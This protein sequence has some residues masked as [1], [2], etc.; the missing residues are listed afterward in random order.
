MAEET[1][2]ER[3]ERATGKRVSD[4]REKGNVLRSREL[5]TTIL[6][7]AS[8]G[9][10][11][12][13]GGGV[14]NGIGGVFRHQ[15]AI[16]R[17]AVFDDHAITE[18]MKATLYHVLMFMAPFFILVTLA[19]LLAPLA[20]GGIAFST[21]PLVID[22]TKLNPITGLQRVVGLKG[23]IEVL[24]ALAKF[25]VIAAMAVAVL[26]HWSSDLMALGMQGPRRALGLTGGYLL[27]SFLL[28]SGA[29]ALIAAVDVPFQRW[30]YYRQL[31]MTRQEIK[32]E[33]KETDG[34]PEVK[35][36]IRTL[37]REYSRRRMMAAVPKADVVVVNPQHYAVALRYDQARMAAPVVVAKGADY[38]AFQ[39]RSIAKSHHV[40]ILSAP[41]LARAIY[42]STE[43]DQEIPAGLYVAV[44]KVLAYVYQLRKW[45]R[46]GRDEPLTMAEEL[47]IPDE[48]KRGE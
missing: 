32:D 3:T 4:A 45:H 14:L 46:T 40:P 48:L 30:D 5:N 38:V 28:I 27:W 10:L 25:A 34:R 36:R 41:A 39:I 13:L 8:G 31:K 16:E 47:P 12:M 17:A 24:K 26:W 1:A 18:A 43:L 35:G 42:F 29:M 2:Q 15:L 37:Q 9:G 11:F 22:F 21:K 19:A 6:L 23:V 44:A 7:L 20:F 33:F